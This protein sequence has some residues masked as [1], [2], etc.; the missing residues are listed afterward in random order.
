MSRRSF[1]GDDLRDLGCEQPGE[2]LTLGWA[3]DGQEL[4]L[5]APGWR[6]APGT[7]PEQRWR[8]YT[9]RR[10]DAEAGEVDVDVVL[11]GDE[12]CFSAWAQR[13]RPGDR[14]GY[15]GPRVDW[16][17]LPDARWQVLF[18]DETALPAIAAVL[19]ALDPGV[20]AIV[21][22]EVAGPEA[23]LDLDGPA[24]VDLRWLHRGR[25]PG[26][27]TPALAEAVGAVAAAL[28]AGPG[29]A[30]GAGESLAVR[31]ARRALQAR[32]ERERV[33]VTGYWRHRDTPDDIGSF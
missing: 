22:C 6:F 8:N 7:P 16:A 20:R 19:E 18:G 10:H 17:P 14:I 33:K 32:M 11:H 27:P 2:I 29:Q 5:P 15:A 25:P 23:E 26:A 30:W 28:P 4:V 1:S 9:V 21:R 12:G 31:D 13:A 3:P 24:D